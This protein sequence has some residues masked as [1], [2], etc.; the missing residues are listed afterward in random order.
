V[1]IPAYNAAQC[2]DDALGSVVAQSYADWEVVVADDGSTDDTAARAA[3]ADAR[4]RVVQ[5]TGRLGPA[6]ARNTAL[7]AATGELVA[8]LDADDLWLPDY[9]ARQVGAFDRE[10]AAPGPA[11]GIVA[12]DAQVVTP[13]GVGSRTFLQQFRGY[14]DPITLE[15]VLKQNRV[16]VSA[17]VPR[18]AGEE[19]GWFEPMLFG[20]EDHDLWIRILE[21][22]RRAVL[23]LD[24]LATY[25]H[26]PGSVSSHVARQAT[27]DQ[28]T[29][30]RALDRGRLDAHQR[31]IAE[32]EL[33]YHEVRTAVAEAW[34]E[35]SP[36]GLARQLPATASVVLRNPGRWRDWARVL[37]GVRV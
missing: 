30:R 10:S 37:A 14:G 24:V 1:I 31:R 2:I 29:Y 4:V 3:A 19:V 18:D 6:G 35:R 33:R 22:G 20:T 8:F 32:S 25:R 5:T 9:L 12:C 15:A 23:N 28:L 36:G 21:T 27:N 17:L 11:V 7:A 13:S 16:Y 34:F 26:L